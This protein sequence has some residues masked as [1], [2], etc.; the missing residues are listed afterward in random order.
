M[1]TNQKAPPKSTIMNRGTKSPGH[2][3][4][5]RF[6]SD[7]PDVDGLLFCM[8]PADINLFE[9]ETRIFHDHVKLDILLDYPFPRIIN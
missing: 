3:A 2:D 5:L 9:N 4:D 6:I 8:A 7:P 1:V